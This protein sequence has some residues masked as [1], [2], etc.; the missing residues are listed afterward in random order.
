MLLIDGVKY[1]LWNPPSEDEFEKVVKE[2]IQE[3]FGE[4]CIYIDKKQK[5]KSLSGI[6]SIPD[7]LA[8]ILG[9]QPELHI[10][11]YELS[12]HDVYGHVVAQVSKFINGLLS[13]NT[14]QKIARMIY[15]EISGDPLLKTRVELAL[16]SSEIF[17]FSTELLENKPVLTIVI[18]NKT[19]ELSEA[20]GPFSFQNIKD[21][22][23]V[24]FQT[25]TRENLGLQVHAHLFEP[26]YTNKTK[27]DEI[28]CIPKATIPHSNK[29]ASH[30]QNSVNKLFVDDIFKTGQQIWGN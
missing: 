5:F 28:I 7:G 6:G 20:L 22:K 2:H 18:E 30:S 21:M 16:H 23:V 19:V 24:E 3:I 14:R 12:N 1:E 11:E 29:S 25:F 27:P 15:D 10:I 4:Q 13:S 9:S 26:I 8:L 17:K